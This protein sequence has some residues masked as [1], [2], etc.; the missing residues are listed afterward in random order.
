ML[1]REYFLK[2]SQTYGP[3]D[4]DGASGNDGMD[5]Q[6]AEDLLLSGAPISGERSTKVPE[7]LAKCA[8]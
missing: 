6:V 2:N 8:I 3:F 4:L 1:N 7:I 5:S